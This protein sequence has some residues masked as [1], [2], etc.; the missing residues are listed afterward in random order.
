METSA[1]LSLQL[2]TP[3]PATPFPHFIPQNNPE[4]TQFCPLFEILCRHS[5]RMDQIAHNLFSHQ[6]MESPVSLSLNAI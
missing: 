5:L 6:S 3:F 4:S 1:S 2:V